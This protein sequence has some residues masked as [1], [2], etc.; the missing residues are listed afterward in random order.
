MGV[1]TCHLYPNRREHLASH[2]AKPN[3]N[4]APVS[5][6][7]PSNLIVQNV[8]D[9]VEHHHLVP[10]F[11]KVGFEFIARIGRGIHLGH[12]THNRI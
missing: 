6:G 12:S 8:L 11:D 5:T 4:G 3:K 9:N 1:V 2:H 7:T 10:N